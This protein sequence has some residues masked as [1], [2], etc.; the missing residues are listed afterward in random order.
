MRSGDGAAGSAHLLGRDRLTRIVSALSG[1]DVRAIVVWS[2]AGTGKSTLLDAWA[3]TLE[4]DGHA[5]TRVSGDALEAGHIA[6]PA[7]PGGQRVL[8]IDDVHRAPRHLADAVFEALLARDDLR[9]VVA[10]R[11]NP[12]RSLTH[13]AATGRLLELR[14][15]DLAFTPEECLALA[16]SHGLVLDQHDVDAVMRRTG[17]WITGLSLVLPLAARSSDPRAQLRHFASDNR[18][19]SDYLAS[20]V[21]SAC[22]DR[23]QRLLL[24]AAVAGVVPLPLVVE[25]AGEPA[26]GALLVDL[27][28]RLMMLTIADEQVVFH[29]AL[30][31]FLRAEA[32][33]R[34][35][36]RF[37]HDHA[38][39][40]QW[41]A[42]RGDGARALR[43][44]IVS[45][46]T[47]VLR[48]LL[49]AV[50]VDLVLS[51]HSAPVLAAV[52]A[53]PERDHGLTECTALLLCSVPFTDRLAVDRLLRRADAA[54]LHT[55]DPMGRTLLAALHVLA[56]P[57]TPEV[58]EHLAALTANA[59]RT[60][61]RRCF[62]VDLLC[63]GAEG[64][65]AMTRGETA[66]ATETLRAVADSAHHAGYVWL[67]W[68]VSLAAA[69]G[70]RA[71]GAWEEAAL[72]ED[73]LT[74]RAESATRSVPGRVRD[75]AVVIAAGRRYERCLPLP[76]DPLES[77]IRTDGVDGALGLRVPAQSLLLLDALDETGSARD[78]VDELEGLLR[79]SGRQYPR[80]LAAALF[81]LCQVRV[82]RDGRAAARALIDVAEPILGAAALEIGLARFIVESPVDASASDRLLAAA[83]ARVPSW[84][85]GATVSAWLLLATHAE[86]RGRAL[87][88]DRRLLSALAHAKR[89]GTIRPFRA[90]GDEGAAL[91][92]ARRGRLGPLE[93][94]A[95]LILERCVPP[96][97]G[98]VHSAA[99]VHLTNRE[100]DI[101][102]EL[103]LHQSLAE[104]AARQHL[105]SN[106][107]K[108]HVR[109]IYQKLGVAERSAAVSAARDLGL[110]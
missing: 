51:G 40:A 108:T 37:Q 2:G 39:A 66:G 99:L 94:F 11:H 42:D 54:A 28:R 106:T 57:A 29:P 69:D 79:A 6:E 77:I 82:E 100:R 87:E 55:D 18:A 19:V 4:Q 31:D 83:R 107:V 56:A 62:G 61:R 102:Q 7:A 23:E 90:R 76:A 21:L 32:R 1:P 3:R 48:T 75:A 81:R 27:S 13:L 35:L 45:G 33:N 63:T 64:L 104:I 85:A 86:A 24:T 5:L 95:A 12:G 44:A 109:A 9:L 80:L 16:A 30:V 84:H 88:A 53:I 38:R 89:F 93:P 70:A 20:E 110:L 14:S 72:V 60:A 46:D 49:A 50:A 15:D 92:T 78:T 73:T 47:Q 65:A 36:P 91:L 68:Q 67:S 52:D 34:D 22:S 74:E 17:G 97:E 59:G 41:F 25:L 10:G 8:M 105:S 43:H 103:P 101:L 71:A 96:S 26:A 98:A 58:D